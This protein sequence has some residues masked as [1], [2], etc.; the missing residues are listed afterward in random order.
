VWTP[1]V[2]N[3]DYDAKGQRESIAYGNGA[4]TD[5]SYDPLTFRLVHLLT[6]RDAVASPA[7]C[8]RP[9]P[10]GWPGCAAQNLRYTYDPAG[11]ITHIRDDAQQTI[12]FRNRRVEPSADYT[13]DAIYR[14]IEAT[15]REHLGQTG[16][17]PAPSSW[18]D[19]PRTGIL[20]SASDGNA[21]SR[22]LERY[23]Y[24][25]VGNFHKMVHRG[26]DPVN[27]GWTRVYTYDEASLLEPGEQSNR[28]T[29]TTIGATSAVYSGGG[30]GYDAHGNMLR[31]PH[32]Q[33]MQWDFKDQLQM[34]QRQ[35]VNADARGGAQRQGE[36]TWYVYDA[37]GQ[38]VRKVTERTGGAIKDERTYLGGFEIY[39]RHGADPLVRETLHVVDDKRRIALVET[40][41]EG[42]D[43]SPAQFIRYQ[44]AN[45]LGSASLE[46]DNHAQVISYEEY[47]P[48]GSTSYQ[49]VRSRTETP[50]RYRYTGKERDEESGLNYHAARYYANWIGRWTSADPLGLADGINLFAYARLNPILYTDPDGAQASSIDNR[51]KSP[52]PIK[53]HKKIDPRAEGNPFE[54]RTSIF[55]PSKNP[56]TPKVTIS[57]FEN[58]AIPSSI[59]GQDSF[60][61]IF[62][63]KSFYATPVRHPFGLDD[64]LGLGKVW[65][66]FAFANDMSEG[67]QG[68]Q[69]LVRIR[70]TNFQLGG[71]LYKEKTRSSN[72]LG[73]GDE[74]PTPFMATFA[75]N[76]P[77]N[78]KGHYGQTRINLNVGFSLGTVFAIPTLNG[79]EIYS[80]PRPVGESIGGFAKL[81]LRLG[82]HTSL[83]LAV[84]ATG[85]HLD[86]QHTP[87]GKQEGEFYH[88]LG[89]KFGVTYSIFPIIAK[90]LKDQW[91]I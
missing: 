13:Y 62:G 23:I 79:V 57:L 67:N 29:S 40:R 76:I 80:L 91:G 69:V 70:K 61:L 50:K 73:F 1:F 68:L 20:F 14:L 38:R 58:I 87:V 66:G 60:P 36:R 71:T 33:V 19:E 27:P 49:A 22:Y 10:A 82:K 17:G 2:V 90:K 8:P 3:I 59:K 55:P 28:L 41:T 74:A 64:L 15:G 56:V 31:M 88:S 48:Y 72:P 7:D 53:P 11:N 35:A 18:N 34:T 89:F 45:H 54:H 46:L 83:F 21:M 43:G 44:L 63:N 77:L 51:R 39:R 78:P 6:R 24:D 32:L 9:T 30:D 65:S 4:R 84:T 85:V 47:F 16:A 37:S 26:S 5:C 86:D 75:K 25:A 12:Y 42:D 52:P 81:D